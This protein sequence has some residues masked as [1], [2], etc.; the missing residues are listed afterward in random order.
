MNAEGPPANATPK[1][2]G[3]RRIA[4]TRRIRSL[5]RHGREYR[6]NK[7]GLFGLIVLLF[8]IGMA[9]A[10]PLFIHPDDL[11]AVHAPGRPRQAPSSTFLL[12]TDGYGRS[13][14]TVTIW[15]ARFSLMVGVLATLLSIGLGALIGVTAAHFRGWGDAVLMRATD[16]F[17]VMPTL[18]LAAVLAAVLERG[19]TTVVVAIGV[20]VWPMTGRLVRAQALSVEARPYIERS[21]ALG[22]GHMHIMVRHV[23]PSVMPVILAQATLTVSNAIILEATLAFLGLG[24]PTKVSWGTSLQL[25]N[26]IGA[27]SAGYWWILLPPG[28]AIFVVSLAFTLCGRALEGVLN[29]RLHERA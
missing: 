24:D 13:M 29:P 6:L 5:A 1:P 2:A 15:G 9:V 19:V 17:L 22:A 7:G 11:S 3:A 28:I 14:V 26:Q 16:W 25:A 12:G 27:V 18:V 8:V 10:A 4:W 21:K 20:T 23:L